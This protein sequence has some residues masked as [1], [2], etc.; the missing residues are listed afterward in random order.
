M[1]P[2]DASAW[3]A[4]EH[5]VA[6]FYRELGAK[7]VKLNLDLGGNQIDVYIEE[8][9]ASGQ[10]V[11]SAVECKFYKA[12]VPKDVVIQFGTVAHFLRQMGL[13]DKAV[14]VTSKGYTQSASIA[15]ETS[16]VELLTFQ[17]LEARLGGYPRWT[18]EIRFSKFGAETILR[19]EKAVEQAEDMPLPDSFPNTVFVAMPFAEQMEDVYIYGIRKSVVEHGLTCKRADEIEHGGPI[20]QEIID[21]ILRC[22]I[23]IAEI[24]DSNPNVFYE[25]GWAHALERPTILLAREGTS[26]PFDIAHVNTII[27]KSIH[28]LEESLHKRLAAELGNQKS[29]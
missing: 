13:I 5:A 23:I 16:G 6:N 12:N 24:S 28:N 14:M 20:A 26:L 7:T 15:A 21:Q 8:A 19:I 27:Y 3:H 10:I 17:D 9:T 4:L 25:V 22:R 11:R 1:A 18:P 2:Q 29:G